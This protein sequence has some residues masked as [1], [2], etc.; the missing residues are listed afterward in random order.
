MYIHEAIQARTADEP[1]ISREKWADTFGAK[2]GVRLFPTSSPDGMIV[3]SQT[4]KAPC[5]GWQPT[6]ED[7]VADDWIVTV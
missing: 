4:A 7:L 3:V 5:R 1:F 2:R 6:A